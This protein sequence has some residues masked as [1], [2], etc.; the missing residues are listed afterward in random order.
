MSVKGNVDEGFD[1]VTVI[2]IMF[3]VDD[4]KTKD[5]KGNERK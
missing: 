4:R 2:P 1:L 3:K 5:S